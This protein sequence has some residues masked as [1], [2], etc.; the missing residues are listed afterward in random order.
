MSSTRSP[1]RG[2]TSVTASLTRSPR[3]GH[4]NVRAFTL[5]VVSGPETGARATAKDSLLRVGAAADNDLVLTDPTVSREHLEVS[6]EG[7]GFW[8]RDR[9]SRH[10]TRLEGR[11]VVAAAIAPNEHLLLGKT[12]LRLTLAPR[13]EAISTLTQPHWAGLDGAHVDMRALFAAM[14][15]LVASP[16]VDQSVLIEGETGVGKERVARGLHQLTDETAALTWV[17]CALDDAL[18]HA[19]AAVASGGTLVL[20]EPG[21]LSARAQEQLASALEHREALRVRALTRLNLDALAAQGRF[22]PRLL[23][24][25]STTRLRVPPLR[26]RLSDLRMLVHALMP[27]D[28]SFEITDEFIDQLQQHQWPG[29]VRELR[30]VVWRF[31]ALGEAGPLVLTAADPGASTVESGPWASVR[32]ASLEALEARYLRALVQRTRGDLKRAASEA[33]LSLPSLYRLMQKHSISLKK[34]PR[35]AR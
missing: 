20:D 17:D 22:S 14:A 15:R 5:E 33:G 9:G 10:G 3:L 32:D 18:T 35:D 2:R 4:A 27:S 31:A 6:R 12:V 19:R 29:N 1:T 13:A 30:N 28:A 8:V 7:D 23:T 25:L 11:R 24:C 34:K 26:A 21:L 16:L